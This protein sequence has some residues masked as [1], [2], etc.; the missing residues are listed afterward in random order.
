VRVLLELVLAVVTAVFLPVVLTV[1]SLPVLI[2]AL[3]AQGRR[4]GR[5]EAGGAG[6]E[7]AS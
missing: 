4:D 6:D 5:H 3:A 1:V 2:H 7:K